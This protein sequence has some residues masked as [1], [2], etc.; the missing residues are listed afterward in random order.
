MQWLHLTPE[1]F[2]AEPNPGNTDFRFINDGRDEHGLG[3]SITASPAADITFEGSSSWAEARHE[4]GKRCDAQGSLRKDWWGRGAIEVGGAWIKEE[5]LEGHDERKLCGPTFEASYYLNPDLS[6]ALNGYVYSRSDSLSGLRDEYTETSLELT[7]SHSA[8]R[9]ATLSMIK[10]SDPIREYGAD[11]LWFSLQ[12]SWSFGYN[13]DLLIKIG[14]E[15]GGITCSG[16]I[17]H[18]EP[19]FS[20]VRAELVSRL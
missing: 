4:E 8:A 12:I 13:H 14:E 5:K 10:A 7:L 11:D 1:W 3:L 15:R 18:Y 17:C 20:G 2:D 6:L 16:G 9:S 19:P